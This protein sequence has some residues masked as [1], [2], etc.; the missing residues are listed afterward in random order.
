[1]NLLTNLAMLIKQLNVN[2]AM[3]DTSIQLGYIEHCNQ[4]AKLNDGAE[5][6]ILTSKKKQPRHCNREPNYV[7]FRYQLL[8]HV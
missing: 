7:G 8:S 3:L 6:N 2:T 1:M 5:K 4:G